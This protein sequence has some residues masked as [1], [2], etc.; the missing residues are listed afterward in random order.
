MTEAVWSSHP[1]HFGAGGAVAITYAEEPEQ[2]PVR[3]DVRAEPAGLLAQDPPCKG[4]HP[5]D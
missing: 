5:T 3:S 2:K 4:P 1:T